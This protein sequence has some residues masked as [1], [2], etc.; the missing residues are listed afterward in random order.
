MQLVMRWQGAR[1]ACPDC[2]PYASWP[3]PS[4][5]SSRL[6]E[7]WKIQKTGA[8]SLRP[9]VTSP[10]CSPKMEEAGDIRCPPEACNRCRLKNFKVRVLAVCRTLLNHYRS[11]QNRFPPFPVQHQV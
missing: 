2:W 4:A 8:T 11:L 3:F 7:R 10:A 6:K 9:H 5:P 1:S